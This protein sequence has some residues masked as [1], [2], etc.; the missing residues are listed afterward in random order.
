M[1]KSSLFALL[2]YVCAVSS[3]AQGSPESAGARRVAERDAA[4]AK[5]H[6]VYARA[7]AMKHSDKHH[8]RVRHP[9]VKHKAI[10]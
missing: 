8:A 4:Y 1:N 7:A 3:F 6:P 5:D 2:L 9:R 10:R